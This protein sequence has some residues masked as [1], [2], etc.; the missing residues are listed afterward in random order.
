MLINEFVGQYFVFNPDGYNTDIPLDGSVY[1]SQLGVDTSLFTTHF[2]VLL[3]MIFY[4]LIV[5]YIA[6]R[7]L[8]KERR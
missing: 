3:G 7:L 6:L 5:S 4:Y 8:V 1:L 2:Y